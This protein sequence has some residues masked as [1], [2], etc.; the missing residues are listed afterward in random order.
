MFPFSFYAERVSGDN[1][2]LGTGR[3][4]HELVY[5]EQIL[6]NMT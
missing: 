3:W 2:N 4:Q 1:L 5:V 6:K